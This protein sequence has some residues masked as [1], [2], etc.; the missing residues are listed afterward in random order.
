MVYPK[1]VYSEFYINFRTRTCEK[2]FLVDK[3]GTRNLKAY[4][5]DALFFSI[6]HLLITTSNISL[7]LK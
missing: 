7:V 4:P 1:E 2:V 6:L 3:T 5:L